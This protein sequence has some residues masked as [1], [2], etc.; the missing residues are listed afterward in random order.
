M[1]PQEHRA[2]AA[3]GGGDLVAQLARADQA[4][5]LEQRHAIGE[6]GAMVVQRQQSLTDLPE[7]DTR[8]RMHVRD[9]ANVR[10]RRVNARVYPELG[11]RLTVSR[12]LI[13]VE[14]EHQQP[15]G[16]GQGW[17]GARREDKRIR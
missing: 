8:W 6:Q 17:A 11:V 7:Y 14:V 2:P 16:V 4:D 9:G 15:R 5:P 13:A 12:P 3:E 10:S 1:A